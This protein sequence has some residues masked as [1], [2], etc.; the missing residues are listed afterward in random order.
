MQKV[1]VSDQEQGF[2]Q[3]RGYHLTTTGAVVQLAIGKW[4]GEGVQY[5]LRTGR[6][7][8]KFTVYDGT[9]RTHKLAYISSNRA[10]EGLWIGFHWDQRES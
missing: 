5:G 8:E 6:R 7:E 4:S 3:I 1:E 9:T 2:K 10:R